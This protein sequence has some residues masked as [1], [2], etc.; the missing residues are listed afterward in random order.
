[1]QD[2][3][4][5][6]DIIAAETEEWMKQQWPVTP[7]RLHKPLTGQLELFDLSDKTSQAGPPDDAQNS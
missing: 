3:R 2:R 7:V 1:M 5:L 6:G 4:A